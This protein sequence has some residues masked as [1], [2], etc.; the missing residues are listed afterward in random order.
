MEKRPR[1][2]FISWAGY[3]EGPGS[4]LVRGF[5]VVA[6]KSGPIN[7]GHA[8][9][10]LAKINKLVSTALLCFQEIDEDTFMVN[11]LSVLPVGG[12]GA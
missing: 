4:V 1:Y 8:A 2:Y 5:N 12:A 10:E 11:D 3:S 6:T 7:L 9:T